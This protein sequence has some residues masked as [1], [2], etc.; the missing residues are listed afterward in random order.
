MVAWALCLVGILLSVRAEEARTTTSVP[1]RGIVLRQ[2]LQDFSPQGAEFAGLDLGASTV[3]AA[4]PV[5]RQRA[6][7]MLGQPISLALLRQLANEVVLSY[8]RAGRPLADA[9]VPEQNISHGTVQVIILEARLGQVSVEGA[10]YFSPERIRAAV[11]SRP[12]EPIVAGVMFSDLDWLNENPFR[13]IDLVY[14]R[15]A[16]LSTTDVVLRVSEQ[17]P[18]QLFGGYD[19]DNV[20]SLGRDRWFAGVRAGNLWGREHRASAL[21]SQSADAG[22]YHAFAGEYV[23]P[24]ESRQ[25]VTF[26]AALAEPTVRTGT[27]D[28]VGRSWRGSMRYAGQFPRR[29]I[30]ELGWNLGYEY[31]SSDNDILFGGTNVYSGDYETHEFSVG[32]SGRKPG[33]TG[34]ITWRA[35]LSANPG[36]FGGRSSAAALATGGRERVD[37][38]Y[39]YADFSAGREIHLVRGFTL[40]ISGNLRLSPDRLPPSSGFTLGGSGQLPGYAEAA[41]LGDDAWFGQ[42][43]LQTPIYHLISSGQPGSL[44]GDALRAHVSYSTG[45]THLNDVSAAELRQ[46]LR[47]SRRLESLGVGFNYEFSRRFQLRFVYGWQLRTPAP[48]AGRTSRGHVAAVFNL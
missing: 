24:L 4:D 46:G 15:G 43:R 33:P 25:R 31:R 35:S 28:S 3:A 13:R 40:G 14:S 39:L 9:A 2:A 23:V 42:V 44:A 12:G 22:D 27:F 32:L 7:A 36:G 1:L 5:F 11:R 48:G 17:R 21:Y 26:S 10:N 16:D 30:W 8:R 37:A 38:E 20:D 45:A 6:E 41:A 18:W 19:N 34:E 47:D 29:R